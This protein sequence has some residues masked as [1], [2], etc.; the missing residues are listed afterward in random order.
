MAG[1]LE[2]G[3]AQELHIAIDV[4]RRFAGTWSEFTDEP[5]LSL[6]PISISRS[7]SSS[8]SLK[9]SSVSVKVHFLYFPGCWEVGT[10]LEMALGGTIGGGDMEGAGVVSA[11]G[12][13]LMFFSPSEPSVWWLGHV[14]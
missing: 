8:E 5:E 14:N 13:D 2:A 7:S 11:G 9:S 6:S 4:R 3:V 10:V 12:V 1:P